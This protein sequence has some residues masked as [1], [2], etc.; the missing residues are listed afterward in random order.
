MCAKLGRRASSGLTADNVLKIQRL[1]LV[2]A[3]S[4]R[5]PVMP[6]GIFDAFMHERLPARRANAAFPGSEDPYPA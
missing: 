6:T 5:P 2:R 3:S 1:D 4:Y